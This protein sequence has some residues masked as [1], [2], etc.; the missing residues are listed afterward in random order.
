LPAK[1]HRFLRVR[2]AATGLLPPRGYPGAAARTKRH[3][4]FF[5]GICFLKK[6]IFLKN[7]KNKPFAERNSG[8]P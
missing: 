8:V 4:F 3:R 5:A 6:H 2:G 7:N 1:V